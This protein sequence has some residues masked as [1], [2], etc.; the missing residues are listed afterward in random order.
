MDPRTLRHPL[1]LHPENAPRRKLRGKRRYFRNVRRAAEAFALDVHAGAWWDLW[2]YHA[3]WRGWGNRSLR[4]RLE[5]LRALC[6]VLRKIHAVRDRFATPFQ[7]WILI[8]G[9]DAGQD[10]VYLH[11][12]NPNVSSVFPIRVTD[13]DRGVPGLDA[14]FR[15][16]LPEL[17]VRTG[18]SRTWDAGADA[19]APA[20]VTTYFVWV[21]G[22]G[23]PIADD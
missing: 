12:P 23:E 19:D 4:H 1:R 14:V 8:S 15:E 13:M 9:D 17:D 6:T 7:C 11:T 21:A 20:W 3:D 22:L 18:C 5:H 10:A 2:H 16:L